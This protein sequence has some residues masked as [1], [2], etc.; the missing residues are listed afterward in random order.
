M[1][2]GRYMLDADMSMSLGIVF[3]MGKS[4]QESIAMF[5]LQDNLE[6]VAGK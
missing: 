2:T 3:E 1:G 6:A 5:S 4:L